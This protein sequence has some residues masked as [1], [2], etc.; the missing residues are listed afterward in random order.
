[1]KRDPTTLE[2]FFKKPFGLAL[3]PPRLKM[4]L[5][6]NLRS[7]IFEPVAKPTQ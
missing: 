4:L 6:L 1:M 5:P 3:N 7:Q 2:I